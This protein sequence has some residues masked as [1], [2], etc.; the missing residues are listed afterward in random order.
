MHR[1]LAQHQITTGYGRSNRGLPESERL[2]EEKF[3][4]FMLCDTRQPDPATK[5]LGARLEFAVS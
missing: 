3:C 1:Q 4:A 2:S 5:T